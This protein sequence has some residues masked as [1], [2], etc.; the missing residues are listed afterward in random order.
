[1]A[2]QS[3]ERHVGRFI[4][5]KCAFTFPYTHP[6]VTSPSSSVRICVSLGQRARTCR[7]PGRVGRLQL[8]PTDHDMSASPPLLLPQPT[9]RGLLS[10]SVCGPLLQTCL[11]TGRKGSVSSPSCRGYQRWR[12]LGARG[13]LQALDISQLVIYTMALSVGTGGEVDERRLPASDLAANGQVCGVARSGYRRRL[14]R[15]SCL[16]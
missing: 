13:R 3:G 4:T 1:M 12:W 16:L 2:T 11:G 8:E 15:S 14:T 9:F 10:G 6:S 5:T 7:I